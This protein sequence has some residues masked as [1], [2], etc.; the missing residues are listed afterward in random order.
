MPDK[1]A[2]ACA[3]THAP[4]ARVELVFLAWRLS[5]SPRSNR[6]SHFLKFFQ[7]GFLHGTLTL[8]CSSQVQA[9]A[10]IFCVVFNPLICMQRPKLI[11]ERLRLN[12]SGL[13]V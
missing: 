12:R 2:T 10:S 4:S 7:S 1:L 3:F 8:K 11:Y 9:N 5:G 6:V 13:I